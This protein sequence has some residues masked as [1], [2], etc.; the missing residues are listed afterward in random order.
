MDLEQYGFKN[1]IIPRSNAL[2]SFKII[3]SRAGDAQILNAVRAATYDRRY[4]IHVCQLPSCSPSAPVACDQL[5]DAPLLH[6]RHNSL[7]ISNRC[8]SDASAANMH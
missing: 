8:A 1:Q 5:L 3:A 7:S 4:V 2:C 6:P